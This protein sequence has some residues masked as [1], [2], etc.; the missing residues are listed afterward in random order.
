MVRHV[1][2][3]LYAQGTNEVHDARFAD[4]ESVGWWE[5]DWPVFHGT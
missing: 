1:T 3:C 2:A 4:V 5:S